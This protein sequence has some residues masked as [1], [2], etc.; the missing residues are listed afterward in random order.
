MLN[1]VNIVS[2]KDV[3]CLSG[4]LFLV[5]EFVKS[6]LKKYLQKYPG[7]LDIREVQVSASSIEFLLFFF[8]YFN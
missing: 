1:H 2:L 6:D 5:F 8:S 3:L 7:L 4:R